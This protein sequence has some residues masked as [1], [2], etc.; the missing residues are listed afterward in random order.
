MSHLLCKGNT[1]SWSYVMC[2]LGKGLMLIL[3][4][5]GMDIL[6]FAGG[7][8]PGTQAL[9]CGCSTSQPAACADFR[10][11]ASYSHP[12]PPRWPPMRVGRGTGTGTGTDTGTGFARFG[13]SFSTSESEPQDRATN[14]SSMCVGSSASDVSSVAFLGSQLSQVRERRESPRAGQKTGAG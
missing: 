3:I 1:H 11:R 14:S 8:L 13:Y 5:L 7:L 9:G 4:C 10:I 12:P 2:S 6:S